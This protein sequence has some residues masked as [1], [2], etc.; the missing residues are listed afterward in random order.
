MICNSAT[1]R[2]FAEGSQQR[3]K[4]ACLASSGTF[5]KFAGSWTLDNLLRL[6][7]FG[8]LKPIPIHF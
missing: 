6:L 2:K 3:C 1:L 8:R 5:G 7:D 4:F